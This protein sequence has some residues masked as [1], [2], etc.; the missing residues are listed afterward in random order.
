MLK[1]AI[2]YT[3][4]DGEEV[5]EEF[6]FNLTQA[7]IVELEVDIEGGLDGAIKHIQATQDGKEIIKL[8]KTILKKAYGKR[9]PDGRRFIKSPE[10]F[11]EF[12]SSEP[13]SV[14]FM[15]LV[16]QAD[17][18][19]NF[20]NGIVPQNLVNEN[21]TQ[22]PVSPNGRTIVGDVEVDPKP[23]PRVLTRAEM[24]EMDQ[25]ELSSGLA[26]GRYQ[27]SNTLE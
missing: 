26:E 23:T 18:A 11:S 10:G 15:E 9:S 5:T 22:L 13:Y 27:L 12:E 7:E 17:A 8:F 1:K 2:K 6:Y 21:Q 24:I 19:A 16:T 14:L 20:I 4:F 3:N 25:A